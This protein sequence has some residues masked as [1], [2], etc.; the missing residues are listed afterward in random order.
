MGRQ[1]NTVN[2]VTVPESSTYVHTSQENLVGT[3]HVCDCSF[4]REDGSDFFETCSEDDVALELKPPENM[5]VDYS[6]PQVNGNKEGFHI[7]LPPVPLGD[8]N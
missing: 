3:Y 8:T 6:K 7:T 5:T 1:I 2:I 4:C